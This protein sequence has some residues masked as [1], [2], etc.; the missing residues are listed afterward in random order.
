MPAQPAPP[1]SPPRKAADDAAAGARQATKEA[2]V[3]VLMC[4]AAA[5]PVLSVLLNEGDLFIMAAGAL[6]VFVMAIG[7]ISPSID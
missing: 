7:S 1:P 2:L 4:A 3:D 5:L 6:P